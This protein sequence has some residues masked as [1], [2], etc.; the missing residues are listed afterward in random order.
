MG[1]VVGLKVVKWEMAPPNNQLQISLEDPI[2]DVVVL[3][4]QPAV[5][6]SITENTVTAKPMLKIGLAEETD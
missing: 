1:R 2:G 6:F 3:V 5:S 4:V